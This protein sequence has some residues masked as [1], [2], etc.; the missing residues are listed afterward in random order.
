MEREKAPQISASKAIEIATAALADKP[1]Y[2]CAEVQLEDASMLPDPSYAA[3]HW[4]L[5]FHKEGSKLTVGADRKQTFGDVEI[6]VGLDGKVFG[7]RQI[8]YGPLP[9]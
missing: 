6:N 2:Y 7:L 4:K 1:G 3:R 5:V 9:K 8:F